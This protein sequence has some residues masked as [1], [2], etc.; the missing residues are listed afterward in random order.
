MCR[1]LN[2]ICCVLFA[3]WCLMLADVVR[4]LR[5]AVCRLLFVFLLRIVSCSLVA[6]CRVLYVV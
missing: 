6:V 2:G 4:W 1:E 3:V 5:F